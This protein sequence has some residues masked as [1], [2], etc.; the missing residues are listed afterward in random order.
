MSAVVRV[1]GISAVGAYHVLATLT[2]DDACRGTAGPM[3]GRIVRVA[4]L[5][6]VVV[7]A[8]AGFRILGYQMSPT[9]YPPPPQMR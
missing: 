5:A 1:E 8:L 2:R 9:V 3:L 4:L 7:T 6:L